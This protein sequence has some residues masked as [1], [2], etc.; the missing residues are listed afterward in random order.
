M[1]LGIWINPI[2]ALVF[3]AIL[4]ALIDI[5]RIKTLIPVGL[6]AVSLLFFSQEVLI[7]L[8]LMRYQ[9]GLVI[10]MGIPMFQFFWAFAAG[11]LLINYMPEEWARKLPV[12]LIFSLVV[13][14]LAYI[15]QLV[16][17][18]QLLGAYNNGYDLLLNFIGLS[19]GV[20]VAEG[21]F[22]KQIYGF[23][24]RLS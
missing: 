9:K 6:L 14:L 15:A 2:Y 1:D 20:W 19:F 7:S 3:W 17:N 16:G 18:L 5:K 23:S 24:K 10:I 12:I 4:F 8:G 21:L 13:Q 11:I 22:K